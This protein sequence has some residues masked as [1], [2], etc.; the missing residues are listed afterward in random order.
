MKNVKRILFMI[1]MILLV[2]IIAIP[3]FAQTNSGYSKKK[4][5][6]TTTKSTKASGHKSKSKSS[7]RS[8]SSAPST[9]MSQQERDRIIKNLIDN[10]VYVEGGTFTMGATSEQ[11]IYVDDDEIPTHQ[12]LLSSFY[13]CKYEVTQEEWLVI[14]GYD[15]SNHKGN[16]YPVENVSWND[17][18]EFISKLNQLTGKSFR[19]P[20]EAEWEFAARGGNKSKGYK[21][22]GGNNIDDVAWYSGNSSGETHVI[23]AKAPN[24]LGLYDM[25]GN[26]WE[27][28][29]DKKGKYQSTNQVNPI[30]LDGMHR[31]YRGGG[32]WF[33]IFFSSESNCR[34]SYRDSDWPQHRSSF[35]GLR[36]AL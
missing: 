31:V 12:V 6:T 15:V 1:L 10:M 7:R 8:H 9:A 36:L 25:S 22:S 23:G 34:I 28:C 29:E 16:N 11:G 33:S 4:T 27:W 5:Q 13:I 2:L 32:S 3:A 24:E 26:V 30:S 19:L 35:I 21:Y 14:M 18:N 17:C 20:T